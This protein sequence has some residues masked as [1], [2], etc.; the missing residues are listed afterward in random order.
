[1]PPTQGKLTQEDKAKVV[2]WLNE[3]AKSAHC[4]VCG[5]NDWTVGDDLLNGMVFSGGNL[6][7]GG[8]AYPMAFIVC[9]NCAYTRQFMAIP[10]GLLPSE[11]EGKNDGE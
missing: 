7:V 1:M 4:P 2:S 6:I 9:N 8:P 11:A 5:V 10:I 3:K